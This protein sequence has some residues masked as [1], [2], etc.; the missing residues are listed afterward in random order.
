MIEKIEK[1]VF[2]LRSGHEIAS[3]TIKGNN[4]EGMKARVAILIRDTSS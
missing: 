3:E 1:R 4:S 2:K